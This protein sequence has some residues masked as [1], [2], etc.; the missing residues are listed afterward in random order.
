MCD[1]VDSLSNISDTSSEQTISQQ[2]SVESSVG[3]NVTSP[4]NVY[5][6]IK[7]DKQVDSTSSSLTNNLPMCEDK[8]NIPDNEIA[9]SEA[10][11][12]T[13]EKPAIPLVSKQTI[14]LSKSKI[15]ATTEEMASVIG[16]KIAAHTEVFKRVE[17]HVC[18]GKTKVALS[19]EK[20]CVSI[21]HVALSRV[22]SESTQ[23]TDL[24][25]KVAPISVSKEAASGSVEKQTVVSVE[26]QIAGSVSVQIP[27]GN[28][29]LV[30]NELAVPVEPDPT[31]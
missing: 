25:K 30:P 16:E 28:T 10:N 21:E 5:K 14:V 13:I 22:S 11:E 12:A 20:K 27:E 29:K 6:A 31:K 18:L 1:F 23:T 26:K 15:L 8:Q 7:V 9:A 17:I 3:M 19:S 24:L 2:L 4:V